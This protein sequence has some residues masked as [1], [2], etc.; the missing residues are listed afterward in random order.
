M[1]YVDA[2][3]TDVEL[4]INNNPVST[5]ERAWVMWF[6]AGLMPMSH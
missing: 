1:N 5:D 2:A 6:A 4:W 3:R